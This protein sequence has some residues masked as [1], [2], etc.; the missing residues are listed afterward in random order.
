MKKPQVQFI[1][2]VVPT[3]PWVPP[4]RPDQ[5]LESKWRDAI[6]ESRRG[7]IRRVGGETM[8]IEPYFS[9]A[10]GREPT[11]AEWKNWEPS[12]G[13]EEVPPKPRK[14]KPKLSAEALMS[15]V[16]FVLDPD[17]D[18]DDPEGNDE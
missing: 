14:A 3:P 8:G 12:E 16:P 15:V 5:N 17:D 10:V 18:D 11:E 7:T 4:E 13:E 1:Q 6:A 2:T 9:L